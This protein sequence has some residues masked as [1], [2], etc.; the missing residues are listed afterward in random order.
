MPSSSPDPTVAVDAQLQN[1]RLLLQLLKALNF[2]DDV[3]VVLGSNGIKL[4]VEE[5]K[6]FQANAFINREVFRFFRLRCEE[7]EAFFQLSLTSLVDCIGMF[8]NQSGSSPVLW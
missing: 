6:A 3:N 1:S 7:E 2:K 4:S 5:S 8:G